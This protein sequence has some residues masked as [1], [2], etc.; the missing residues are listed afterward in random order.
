MWSLGAPSRPLPVTKRL[1]LGLPCFLP[2]LGFPSF[3]ALSHHSPIPTSPEPG[4]HP[5]PPGSKPA[6]SGR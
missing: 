3:L 2:S 6:T 5:V 1:G 4:H